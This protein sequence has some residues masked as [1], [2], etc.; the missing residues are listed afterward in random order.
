MRFHYSP[1]RLQR[2]TKRF[3]SVLMLLARYDWICHPY[4]L[5]TNHYHLLIET[6]NTNL[7]RGV[8][9]LNG[10]YTQWFNHKYR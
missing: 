1:R 4:Y 3:V 6:P 7:S 9:Q 8:R 2:L 10:V 5:M